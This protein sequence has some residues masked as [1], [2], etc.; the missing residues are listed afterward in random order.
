MTRP[1]MLA[2]HA[3][4]RRR[5]REVNG[6]PV[7]APEPKPEPDEDE[8]SPEALDDRCASLREQMGWP[9]ESAR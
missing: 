6:I 5:F 9:K 4:M 8:F 1:D 2:A 7:D 3:D